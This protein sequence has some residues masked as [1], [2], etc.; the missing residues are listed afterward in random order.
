MARAG[1]DERCVGTAT[2]PTVEMRR[3]RC[4]MMPVDVVPEVRLDA[5]RHVPVVACRR[6]RNGLLAPARRPLRLLGAKS[7]SYREEPRHRFL[8]L[9]YTPRGRSRAG[10][11][12]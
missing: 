10:Q 8:F 9:S 1:Q 11:D 5:R 7:M 3:S 2:R 12:E 6:R 4:T